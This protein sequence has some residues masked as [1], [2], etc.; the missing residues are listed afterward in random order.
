MG[1]YKFT[2]LLGEQ[3]LHGSYELNTK[4][5]GS[6]VCTDEIVKGMSFLAEGSAKLAAMRIEN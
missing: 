2:Q 5:D 4:N 6:F 1:H 3:T